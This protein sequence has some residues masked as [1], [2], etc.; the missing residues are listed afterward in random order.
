VQEREAEGGI[1]EGNEVA[2]FALE[3]R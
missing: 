2:N 3:E 1:D